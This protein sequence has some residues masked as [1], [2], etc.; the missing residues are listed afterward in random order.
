MWWFDHLER[1]NS[2]E[3][4]NKVYVS[5]TESRR[6]GRPL[7]RWKDKVKECMHDRVADRGGGIEQAKECMDRERERWR[8]FCHGLP[9]WGTFSEVMRH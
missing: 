3:F 8:L 1:K 4:V 6:K 9:L 7:V 2:E 5:E